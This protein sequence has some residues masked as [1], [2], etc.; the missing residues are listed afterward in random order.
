MKKKLF[1]LLPY[2]AALAVDFYL[3]P[4]LIRD[5]GT[6][7]VLLLCVMPLAA[8]ITGVVCGVR[9]RIQILLPVG[10]LALFL[11][12]VFIYYNSSAWVY[13]VFF[14]LAVLIGNGIGLLFYGKK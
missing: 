7:M 1:P 10:A 13:A 4:L 5:T 6:A 2:F 12:T 14:P 8:L 11:P 9:L 3:L